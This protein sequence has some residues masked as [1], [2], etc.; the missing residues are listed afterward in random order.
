MLLE[1]VVLM[2]KNVCQKCDTKYHHVHKAGFN[3]TDVTAIE[4]G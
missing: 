3:E 1:F 2:L 4:L